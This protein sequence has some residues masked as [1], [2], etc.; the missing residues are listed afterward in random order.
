MRNSKK[1]IYDNLN[2]IFLKCDEDE[3]YVWGVYFVPKH[4]AHKI[5]AAYSSMH[6]ERFLCRMNTR[7][8]RSRL[9]Q[10]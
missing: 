7:N 1:Y 2:T 8:R 4:E 9:F 10:A 3:M 6:F 5:D